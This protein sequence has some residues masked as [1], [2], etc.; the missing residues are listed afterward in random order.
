[1]TFCGPD[2]ATGQILIT[3]H[4]IKRHPPDISPLRLVRAHRKPSGRRKEVLMALRKALLAGSWYPGSASGCR[5]QID[6]FLASEKPEAVE[7]YARHGG[8]VPHAGWVYSG[9]IACRVF[10][11]LA[12]LPPPDVVI[13]FGMHMHTASTPCIMTQGEWESPLGP[14]PIHAPLASDL[15][16]EFP[17]S[18]DNPGDFERDNTIEL[19]IPFIRHFFP[20][21]AFIPVGVPP[22]PASAEMGAAAVALAKT[23]NL[24]LLAIGSTDLTHYGPNYGF[25]PE[26]GGTRAVEWVKNDN[27]RRAIQAIL[28]LDPRRVIQE[29]LQSSNACCCG[30]VSAAVAAAAAAGARSPQL[31]AY[32]TSYDVRPGASFVGYA[33]IVF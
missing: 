19:Q 9:N 23:R 31:L 17:F 29:G 4:Q 22:T 8:V 33:G 18:R 25:M 20:D 10:H 28:D 1:M 6:A 26:G 3:I 15:A 21:A 14:V 12:K 13:V 30:A 11:H 5:Q 32:G 16:A 7:P 2:P 27:D 24:T